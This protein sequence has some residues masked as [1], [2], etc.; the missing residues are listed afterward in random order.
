MTDICCNE[1]ILSIAA[2]TTVHF[3]DKELTPISV[4]TVPH[5]QL[6]LVIEG[7]IHVHVYVH[8]IKLSCPLNIIKFINVSDLNFVGVVSIN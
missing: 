3:V 8:V 4:S 2:G 5:N 1:G 6:V 7:L